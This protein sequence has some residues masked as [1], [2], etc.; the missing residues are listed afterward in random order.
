[1]R[2]SLRAWVGAI[3]GRCSIGSK[4]RIDRRSLRLLHSSRMVHGSR[5]PRRHTKAVVSAVICVVMTMGMVSAP[6]ASASIR[7]TKTDSAKPQASPAGVM[8][9]A[10]APASL[11]AA[12]EKDLLAK[13]KAA[14]PKDSRSHGSQP[15]AN[16]NQ[17]L[18]A[19]YTTTGAQLD[20]VGFTY[21]VGRG[22]VGRGGS[23]KTLSNKLYGT[24]SAAYGTGDVTD[25]FRTVASGIEQS[26]QVAARPA[27]PGSLQIDVPVSGL[28]ATTAGNAIDLA[29]STGQVRATYS[30]LRVTDAKDKVIPSS[31]QASADGQTIV[32]DVQ[33]SAARYPLTVDPT[34]T[35]ITELSASDGAAND[36]FANAVA[37]SG[38]LAVVGD[39]SY[40]SGQG[41]AY[42]FSESGGSW[43]QTAELSASDGAGGD[44]FGQSV[45]I[46]GDTI[47]VGAP[48]HTVSSNTTQGTAYV[49]TES[50]GTWSQTDELT[51]SDGAAGD[52]FGS[53]VALFDTTA[54][55]GAIDHTVG[56]NSD[57]GVAYVFTGSGSAWTQA[58]ELTASDGAAND[59]FGDAVAISGTTAVIG[60]AKHAVSGNA[61]QGAAYVFSESG[62]A[63]AQT[64]ELTATGGASGDEFGSSVAISGST[65]VVGAPAKTVSSH[66]DQGAVY[67]FGES[68]STWTQISE[69]TA[70]D[71][72]AN[73][74]FGDSVALSGTTAIVGAD[75]HTVSSHT[76]QGGAYV[77][78]M[79]PG[80]VS[81]SGT[82]I[83][84]DEAAV[85]SPGCTY[86][87]TDNEPVDCASGDLY[88]TF[89]DISVPGY[90]PALDLTRTYNS[91]EAS[92]EG[93]FG[94]G[95]SSSYDM[96]LTVNEDGSITIT[97]PDGS[98]VTATLVGTDYTLPT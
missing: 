64:T 49:F 8:T 65:I 76:D 13:T 17:D 97:E 73:D 37:L 30:G 56:T 69:L 70:S 6:I 96:H 74:T 26:F 50:G 59:Q 10:N 1:M 29:D 28:T 16:S 84:T 75:N 63:W 86:A 72:S 9:L 19:N 44:A 23:M 68:G 55:I 12:V 52:K 93:I 35:Q 43:S 89:T 95:W 7:S 78:N 33:D 40:S 3:V 38:S 82:A 94:Y 91:L 57:Q 85:H 61:D 2:S 20:G 79:T 41:D 71:G 66:A 58:A 83:G 45:T 51:A 77:F 92:T 88:R 21:N 60:A 11:R 27:G 31:M 62:S 36:Q 98:Q 14:Q 54:I 81:L 46:A 24:T 34:W 47:V 90:G 48:D 53:S 25:S 87:K 80:V 32:I 4:T 42:V 5:M 22:S 67:V 39:S 18:T 15:P